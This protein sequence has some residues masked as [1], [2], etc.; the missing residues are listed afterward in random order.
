MAKATWELTKPT[1]DQ[2]SYIK[3]RCGLAVTEIERLDHD[4]VY[5]TVPEGEVEDVLVEYCEQQGIECRLL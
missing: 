5:V 1:Y 2:V 4:T 3:G